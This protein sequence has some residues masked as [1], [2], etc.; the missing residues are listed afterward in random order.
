MNL[1][2]MM[3]QGIA[4]I[5][6]TAGRF[7]LNNAK[8]R[9]FLMGL[10]PELAKSTA[11]RKQQEKAGLHVPPFLIASI[12]SQCNL[13]CAGCYARAG[14]GC[15]TTS[16]KMDMDADQWGN[17]FDQAARLGVVFILLAGGEPFL[18][19][20]ILELAGAYP[21]V[22]FPIFTNG[23]MLDQ[24]TIE[25]LDSHRNLIP[26]LSIEGNAKETDG[27]RGIGTHAQIEAAMAALKER[28]ILFGASI[29]VTRENMA[30][31]TR[32]GFFETLEE[33][34]CGVSLYIEYVPAEE[35]TEYLELGEAE[36]KQLQEIC[37]KLKKS[38]S[39]M[40]ILSFPGDEEEMGGCLASGRGFF[41]INPYGD[42]EPCPFSPHA[43][44]NLISDSM[45]AV[46]R[47]QYFADLRGIA[48]NAGNH[49]GC[50]LFE[51]KEQVE[52]LWA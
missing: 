30:L 24:E 37:K 48:A 25:F 11:R 13:H 51:E 12:A 17:I 15:G 31:V 9:A 2:K 33:K 21:N 35:G 19:R 36:I 26:I 40:V 22:I 27:R 34:G 18:R 6:T 1:N 45:E 29:T 52:K 28:K 49:G 43:K 38:F 20:D 14:G 41:H 47:S 5:M 42:A 23:T 32:K 3:D 16:D 39:K 46:L 4:Q 10:L 8:G 44:Q 50:T 7:Y